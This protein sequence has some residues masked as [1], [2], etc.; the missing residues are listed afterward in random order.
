MSLTQSS[1]LAAPSAPGA[2]EWHEE[3]R[4]W[5]E[6]GWWVRWVRGGLGAQEGAVK[7]LVGFLLNSCE[8][9]ALSECSQQSFHWSLVGPCSLAVQDHCVICLWVTQ[10]DFFPG[11]PESSLEQ[12]PTVHLEMS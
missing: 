3:D 10:Q 9:V 12:S 8:I 11:G 2:C 4:P 5:E 1:E 6:G 7:G